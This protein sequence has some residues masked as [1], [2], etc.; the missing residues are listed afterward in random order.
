M[1]KNNSRRHVPNYAFGLLKERFD[2]RAERGRRSLLQEY[3]W[4]APQLYE[5]LIRERGDVIGGH[6]GDLPAVMVA[7]DKPLE[8]D[9][10]LRIENKRK[11]ELQLCKTRCVCRCLGLPCSKHGM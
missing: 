11:S 10:P 5:I 8:N 4:S 2:K 9:A 7:P 6:M 3:R 1:A